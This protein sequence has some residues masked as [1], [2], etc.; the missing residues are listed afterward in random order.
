VTMESLRAL[1]ESL[2]Q[3]RGR[4]KVM[5]YFT[6][7]LGMD[8]FDTLDH[9]GGTRSIAF[10]DFHAAMSAATRGN[11]AIYPIDP[12]GLTLQGSLSEAIDLR[13]LAYATGG[14]AIVNTNSIASGLARIV[15][16]NSTYYVLGFASTNDRREGRFR[17]VQVQV[18]RPGLVVRTRTGY[19]EPQRHAP[20][21]A[22][23]TIATLPSGLAKALEQPLAN[24]SVPM[25]VFAA[26]YRSGD[27][28]ATIVIAQEMETAALGLTPGE[29]SLAGDIATAAVAV[30][31]DGKIY[32]GKHQTRAVTVPRDGANGGTVRIVSQIQVPPGRYQLRVAGGTANRAGS[33]MYDV[34]VPD[35]SKEPLTMS[36]VALTSAS[37][38]A[39]LVDLSEYARTRLPTS[40]TTSREFGSGEDLTLYAEVYENA[41]KAAAH[42]VDVK[43]E[44][45]TA[46]GRVVRTISQQRASTEVADGRNGFTLT[47]PLNGAAAGDHV[48]RVEAR[49]SID[50]ETV[51][52]SIPI[53]IR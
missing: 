50:D 25:T 15:R 18:S 28:Q 4:R 10:D 41:R 38:G 45:R 9:A 52:S 35:Y 26:P 31:F 11:I 12:A 23:T 49:S 20:K 29:D 30:R 21:Q 5:L 22:V 13:A 7:G 6:H 53:R 24:R 27:R 8:V 3:I 39:M 33:V 46:D 44:L 51:V 32:G 19:L 43:V 48:L 37:A 34:D 1:T 17:K 14:D 36:G 42:N 40:L 16:E 47:V 2:A